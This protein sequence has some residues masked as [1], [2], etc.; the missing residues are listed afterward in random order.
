MM[1]VLS[2]LL[3][4]KNTI[5]KKTQVLLIHRTASLTQ[6][7]LNSVTGQLKFDQLVNQA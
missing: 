6:Q 1:A 4:L 7:L 2:V 5:A 3:C